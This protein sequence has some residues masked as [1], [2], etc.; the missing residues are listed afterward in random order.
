MAKPAYI[1]PNSGAAPQP[2]GYVNAGTLMAAPNSDEAIE[3]GVYADKHLTEARFIYESSE[4]ADI[5]SEEEIQARTD[6][7]KQ[8]A[9]DEEE[10]KKKAEAEGALPRTTS[11]DGPENA[12]EPP[13]NPTADE[14]VAETK[15][16]GAE[17]QNSQGTPEQTEAQEANEAEGDDAASD[18]TAVTETAPSE[19][20]ATPEDDSEGDDEQPEAKGPRPE[21]T[22][23]D[24]SDYDPS[25]KT[26]AQVLDDLTG[27]DKTS[28]QQVLDAEEAGKNRST[29]VDAL[30]ER[31][32]SRS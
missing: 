11:E 3:V 19:Q 26:V 8:I 30:N 2:G 31:L 23:D 7:L 5:P 24:F 20:P 1:D 4:L 15:L 17:V 6:E 32:K 27:E 25:T 29:L 28:L 22:D 10:A 12:P 13:A 21:D 18:P 9:K 14:A 16:Q